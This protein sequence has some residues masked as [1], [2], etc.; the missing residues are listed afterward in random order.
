MKELLCLL[1]ALTLILTFVPA[2]AEEQDP[3]M[4][5]HRVF[6]EIFTGSFSD[7]VPT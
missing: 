7:S 2:C 5:N 1:A 6:Y 4:D 3:V